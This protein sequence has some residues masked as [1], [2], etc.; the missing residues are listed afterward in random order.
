MRQW[1]KVASTGLGTEAGEMGVPFLF[2]LPLGKS[3]NQGEGPAGL[4]WLP[5]GGRAGGEQEG[6]GVGE[7]RSA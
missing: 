7:S 4:L 2:L 6:G 1:W 3:R 5:G